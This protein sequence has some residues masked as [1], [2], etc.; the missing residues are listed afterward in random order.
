M[1]GALKPKSDPAVDE[2]LR[3]FARISNFFSATLRSQALIHIL[4]GLYVSAGS[5]WSCTQHREW[6]CSKDKGNRSSV[7]AYHHQH[8]QKGQL[9]FLFLIACINQHFHVVCYLELFSCFSLC[10]KKSVPSSIQIQCTIF[11]CDR[12]QNSVKTFSPCLRVSPMFTGF[13]Y[14]VLHISRVDGNAA[15]VGLTASTWWNVTPL[16]LS[17]GSIA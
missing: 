8:D 1:N 10:Q 3:D 9:S 17:H 6:L 12:P 15:T 7:L 11:T 13:H 5:G 2:T 14:Q 4:L 16:F